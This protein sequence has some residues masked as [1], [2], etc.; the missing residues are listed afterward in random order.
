MIFSEVILEHLG[1]IFNNYNFKII[2]QQRDFIE[3][4]SKAYKIIIAYNQF[5]NLNTFLLGVMIKTI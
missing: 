2:E 4:Q 3:L 5:E 1:T